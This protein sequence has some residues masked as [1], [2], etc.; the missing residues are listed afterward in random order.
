VN[1]DATEIEGRW[2]IPQTPFAGKFLMIRSGG[3]KQELKETMHEQ[4]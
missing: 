2:K 3:A 4:A 1:A